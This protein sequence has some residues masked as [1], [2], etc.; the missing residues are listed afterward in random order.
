MRFMDLEQM[1]FFRERMELAAYGIESMLKQTNCEDIYVPYFKCMAEFAIVLIEE[2]RFV[3]SGE[4]KQASLEELKEHNRLLYQ[5]IFPES[6]E[7]SF[8]NPEYA[9]DQFGM[10]IGRSLAFLAAELRG[11]IG[12]IYEN[13]MEGVVIRLELVLEVYQLFVCAKEES[14]NISEREF[15]QI[16]Y[17]YVSD[18]SET[19]M[20][21]RT[22][23][24]V[25]SE[26]NF[27]IDIVMRSDLNDLR[28]LYY[29]GE[30]VS[31]NQMNTAKHLNQL[32]DAVLQKM[33]D[34]YTEGY[35]IGFATNNRDI[36]IKKSVEIR[37]MIGMEQMVKKAV[38]NFEKIGLKCQ[39]RRAGSSIFS[40]HSV[41]KNGFFGGNPNKQY[42]FDHKEDIALFLDSLLM[43]RKLECLKN[44]F[45]TYKT[46]AKV[47]GGPA[48]IEIFGEA[49]FEPITKKSVVKLDEEQQKLSVEYASKAGQI[50]NMYIP[51]EERSFTIIAFPVPEI[52][53]GFKEIFDETIRINTLDYKTYQNV[54]QVIIDALDQGDTI[55]VKGYG[56]NRTELTIKLHE[57]QNQEKQTNFENCV[58]DVNIPV[59]EVFTS[60]KLDGT[61]GILHVGC[62]FLNGLAYKDLWLKIEN[63][64]VKEYGCS[65]FSDVKDN[66]KL[67][68]D[69]ILFHHESLPMGEFAIGTN[70]VA[71][72][73]ARKFHIESKLPILIAEK[74]GPHFAF[75]DTCYSHSEEIKVYNPDG[76]EIIARDNEKSILRKQDIAKAYF[77]CHTD[78]T[79]PYDELGEIVVLTAN[80]K[81]IEIIKNGKFVLKGTEL[82]NEAFD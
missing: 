64:M 4:M 16:L 43:N 21:K 39:A 68:Q 58:A 15:Q 25:S 62:V 75:G 74:T 81:R 48:V 19:R 69:N 10:N 24:Y 33:A 18:Y 73:M 57:L 51:G 67:I 50:T 32:D 66:Q 42:D 8:T 6:Y 34:T 7:K 17:W 45:E 35:R 61:N 36:S 76:K 22:K 13:D 55:L 29:Y 20:E 60:P 49:D 59:G 23:D 12:S 9:S 28:Y 11:A 5:D 30:Y 27:A 47:Y 31:E 80:G 63:G 44:S 71:Y 52:G 46:Q 56:E 26:N 3:E 14:L 2:Y 65:N 37:Y 1:E 78:I 38:D 77:N 41:D 72:V 53:N 82:L 54:Q 79:I 40:G 70:T